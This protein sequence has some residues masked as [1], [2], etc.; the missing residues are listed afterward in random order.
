M[1]TDRVPFEAAPRALIDRLKRER[2]GARSLRPGKRGAG[3]GRAGAQAGMAMQFAMRSLRSTTTVSEIPMARKR[4]GSHAH[5]TGSIVRMIQAQRSV[6]AWLTG[7]RRGDDSVSRSVVYVV[8][9]H[10]MGQV[11]GPTLR[12]VSGP[13]VTRY[14]V[15]PASASA[16][17]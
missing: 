17:R 6:I 3:A 8:S 9:G 10:F 7:N 14:A 1:T 13:S 5:P 4:D 15:R 16:G 11:P 2:S 12:R